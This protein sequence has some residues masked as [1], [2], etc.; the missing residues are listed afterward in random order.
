VNLAWFDGQEL[1]QFDSVAMCRQ[2]T[3]DIGATMRRRALNG[4]GIK[5]ILLLLLMI[6]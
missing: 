1:R 3:D 5:V 6:V 4:Y 2:T